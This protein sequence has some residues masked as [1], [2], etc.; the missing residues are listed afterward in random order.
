M[1][2]I[3]I[4]D[5]AI[6]DYSRQ[7]VGSTV[8]PSTYLHKLTIDITG[9][10][11][12]F[13][14]YFHILPVAGVQYMKLVWEIPGSG[15]PEYLCKTFIKLYDFQITYRKPCDIGKPYTKLCSD[16]CTLHQTAFR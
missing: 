16:S 13:S 15:L 8:Q 6:I 12:T 11:G 5:Q 4:R 14:Y 9:M 10:A 2:I 1:A 7:L 3:V